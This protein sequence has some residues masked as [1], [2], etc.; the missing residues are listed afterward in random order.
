MAR[1]LWLGLCLIPVA[2]LLLPCAAQLSWLPEYDNAAQ[3]QALVTIL[4]TVGNSTLLQTRTIWP[5]VGRLYQG[6]PW[7][8]SNTSYCDW[9]GVTCCGNALANDINLCQAGNQS[10]S[11]ISVPDA[12]LKG[13]LPDVFAAI[14]DLQVLDLSYNEGELTCFG[15]MLQ[16]WLCVYTLCTIKGLLAA[17]QASGKA[18]GLCFELA[19]C[20]LKAFRS[21]MCQAACHQL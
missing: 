20:N 8:S 13:T 1:W 4:N 6:S 3:R 15:K 12:E 16:P 11:A 2:A 5:V 9:W 19:G 7:A 17:C 14:S 18:R 21:S 10:I